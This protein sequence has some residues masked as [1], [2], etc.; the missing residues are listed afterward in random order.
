MKLSRGKFLFAAICAFGLTACSPRH[1]P[2]PPLP[3]FGSLDPVTLGAIQDAREAVLRSSDSAEAWGRFAQHLNASEFHNE[4]RICYQ[5]AATLDSN[6]AKWL[7]LL[8]LLQLQNEPDTAIS[9]L[10]RAAALGT[11]DSSH[12]RLAQALTER[13]RY[14][15]AT[16]HLH[17]LLRTNP[18][19]PAARLELA[20]VHLANNNTN[21]VFQLL[22]VCL[23]NP[24]TARPALLLLGQLRAREGET[25]AATALAERA[26]R[27]PRTFDW[28]DPFLREVQAL[29]PQRLQLTDQAGALLSQRRLGEAEKVIAELLRNF[30]GDPEAFLLSGRLL[31]LQERLN[32]AEQRFRE[33]LE[34]NENSLNG[35]SQLALVLLRQERWN[36]AAV[37]LD[38]AI[39]LK[40]DFAQ[41]HANL[42][43]T[44]SRLG[45]AQGAAASYREALRSRPGDARAHLGLAQELARLGQRKEALDHANQAL[46]IDPGFEA[47]RLLRDQLSSDH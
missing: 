30:P 3:Q 32:E 11:N 27:M 47:A 46:K 40:P 22:S 13:G 6:S 10:T 1:A 39:G 43:L 18:A 38:R 41:A 15:D 34:L 44:R 7:H 5:R 14:S 20:R 9:N 25:A 24:F 4:A 16:N 31:L 28:P 35:L 23:T 29:R 36:D 8:A 21:S 33:H 26:A 19:H 12:L 17:A 37:V 2:D 42:A 45:D